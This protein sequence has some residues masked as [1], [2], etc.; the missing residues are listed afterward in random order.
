MAKILAPRTW[1]VNY[2][3]SCKPLPRRQVDTTWTKPLRMA[4]FQ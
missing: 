4:R 3:A 2:K 1:I